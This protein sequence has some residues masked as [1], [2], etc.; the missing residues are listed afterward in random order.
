MPAA[1]EPERGRPQYLDDPVFVELQ[2]QADRNEVHW[3]WNDEKL[4]VGAKKFTH[5]HC[6]TNTSSVLAMIRSLVKPAAKHGSR[7]MTVAWTDPIGMTD[8]SG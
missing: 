8:R 7:G 1:C 6:E 3:S 5:H 4:F 2:Q